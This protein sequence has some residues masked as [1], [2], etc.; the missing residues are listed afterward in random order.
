MIIPPHKELVP[1]NSFIVFG[2]MDS[3]TGPGQK[4]CAEMY[5]GHI[6]WSPEGFF[7]L[8]Q[9]LNCIGIFWLRK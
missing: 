8:F 7:N 5:N 9:G 4:I 1:Y 2:I 3:T 6:Q